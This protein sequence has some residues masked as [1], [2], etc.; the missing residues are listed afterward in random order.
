LRQYLGIDHV[1]VIHPPIDT[2]NFR[3]LGQHAYYLSTARLEPYKRVDLIVRAF[4]EMPNRRLLVASGGSQYAELRELAAEHS[5]IHF[6]GWLSDKQLRAFIGRCIA[7]IYLPVE[8]DFGISPV[9][10]MAAGKPVIGVAEGGLIET[11]VPGETG[12]L[13]APRS[14]KDPATAIAAI[15]EAADWLNADHAAAMRADCE[16]RAAEFDAKIFDRQFRE[17]LES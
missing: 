12:L 5:N 17:F 1:A 13:L 10:S 6:T 2:Q 15:R 8:E 9:E 16:A 11:V 14:L 7:T 3:W 4:M